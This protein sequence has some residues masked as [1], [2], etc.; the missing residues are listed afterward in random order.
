MS[1]DICVCDPPYALVGTA[2]GLVMI[3]RRRGIA[4]GSSLNELQKPASHE[5]SATRTIRRGSRSQIQ[6]E[7]KGKSQD[8]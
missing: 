1:R 7:T 5:K 8:E 2:A 6:S 3:G 4:A